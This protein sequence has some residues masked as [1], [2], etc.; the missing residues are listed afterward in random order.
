MAFFASSLTCCSLLLNC[1]T[2]RLRNVRTPF[3][4]PYAARETVNLNKK[5]RKI[6][7][8]KLNNPTG[9][10]PAETPERHTYKR[11]HPQKQFVLLRVIE[12]KGLCLSLVPKAGLAPLR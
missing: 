6:C 11:N 9:S 8:V 10:N 5:R 2:K 3:R 12:V 1:C 4:I 7:A